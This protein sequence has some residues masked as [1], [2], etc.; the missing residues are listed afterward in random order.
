MA[1]HFCSLAVKRAPDQTS[2]VYGRNGFAEDGVEILSKTGNDGQFTCRGSAQAERPATRST[3]RR[4]WLTT[5]FALFC[6]H[7][8]SSC[9]MT[10]VNARSTSLIVRSE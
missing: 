10:C 2:G 4:T 5:W 7:N 3:C 8:L 9:D 6:S 1:K